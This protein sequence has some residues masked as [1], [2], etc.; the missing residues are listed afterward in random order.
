MQREK[1]FF[2]PVL[3][4]VQAAALLSFLECE[5]LTVPAGE[6]KSDGLIP[7]IE[8]SRSLRSWRKAAIDLRMNKDTTKLKLSYNS[9]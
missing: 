5:D 8:K 6:I 2:P 9:T 3:N 1:K 7:Y 4:F